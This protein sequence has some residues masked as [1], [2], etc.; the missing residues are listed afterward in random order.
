MPISV[1]KPASHTPDEVFGID[2]WHAVEFSRIGRAPIEAFRLG[3][4]ATVQTYSGGTRL[5]NSIA[6]PSCPGRASPP[7]PRAGWFVTLGATRG[8]ATDPVSVA[9]CRA[10]WRTL[11]SPRP[12]TQI[13]RSARCGAPGGGCQEAPRTR[14]AARVRLPRRSTSH[15]PASRSSGPTAASSPATRS[16]FR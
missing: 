10:T 7:R 9:P 8:T 16:L 2:F 15:S 13:R 1:R 5:S 12:E 3:L 4:G 11:D 6:G 14:T